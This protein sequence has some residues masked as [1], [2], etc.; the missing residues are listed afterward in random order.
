MVNV[1]LR[2]NKKR[3]RNKVAH[4]PHLQRIN[5]LRAD[6]HTTNGVKGW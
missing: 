6:S 1:M 2:N 3:K 5:H 4:I